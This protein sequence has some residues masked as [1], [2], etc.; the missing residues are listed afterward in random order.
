MYTGLALFGLLHQ[1]WK[2]RITWVNLGLIL[3]FSVFL[4]LLSARMELLTIFFLL[5][6]SLLIGMYR[7]GQLFKGLIFIG[8]GMLL[9]GLIV[10]NVPTTK[11][12]FQRAI[13]SIINPGTGSDGNIRWRIWDSASDILSTDNNWILGLG[14]G[15]TQIVLD[16]SYQNK[17]YISAFESHLNAH[18]QYIQILLAIGVVG[19]LAWLYLLALGVKWR[20][21]ND[22]MLIWFIAL[23]ALSCLTESM[24]ES[25]RGTLFFCFFFFLLLGIQKNE[26]N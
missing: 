3:L 23:F 18:N 6:L 11:S 9:L 15:D 5:A 12:R 1:C 21:K 8:V 19:L 24:L 20:P 13:A 10:W 22:P 4:I 17:G 25:Q 16:K 14:T 26:K 2:E 7:K